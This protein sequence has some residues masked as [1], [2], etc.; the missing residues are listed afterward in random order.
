M[1][2]AALERLRGA[3]SARP[4]EPGRIAV[5]D[6]LR[7]R[8]RRFEA[9]FVLGLEEGSL[10]A[11]RA[12]VAVPRRRA[13]ARARPRGSSAPT[14]SAATATSSTPP[15][16]ARRGGSISCAR[17]PT[18][19]GAPREP[20]P[21]WH[22]VAAVFDPEDV[23]RATRRRAL[24]EL[25]V[26]DRRARRPS[27]SGCARSRGSRPTRDAAELALALA[28]ANGWARR[29]GRAR[30]AF[31][32]ETRLR[33]P[34]CSRQLGARSDVR[35]HRARALRRLL[36]GLALRA[37]RSTR[38]RSTPRPTRCCAA[39][40]P[41]RRS[42]RSTRGLPKEL[43]SDR[44]TP[45]NARAGA[46]RS[47]A[48]CLD[49]ALRGGVRLDLERGRGGR[50]ARGALARPRAVPPRRGA[51]AARASC[52]GASRSASA[53]S[54]RRPSSSAGSSSAT[55]SSLSGKI[56][57]I[58]VDPFSARGIVQDYKSGKG[59]FSARADR[60]RA[61]PAGAALHA[62]A[63]RPRRDRAARRRLPRARRSSRGARGMLRD[64]ARDDLP[65]LQGERLPRR[66]DVLGAGRDGARARARL[67]R[68]G[69]AA[70]TSRHDPKGGE[71]PA[72]C[73]LWTMCRVRARRDERAAARGGRGARRGVRLGRRRAR[74]RRPC[75]SSGSC[76]RSATTG[77][78]STR[79]SSI[80][81]TRKAA[82]ELRSRIRAALARARP[83]R[84]R[85]RARRRL[86]LDH[87][88]LLRPAPA[89]ASVR[90][91]H[92]PALPR[93]RRRAGRGRPRRGVRARARRV[94]R[95][96]RS[97]AARGC[98]RPTAA[99]RLRRMLTGVYETL[100]SAGRPLVLEL[101]E[102]R[103]P[104]A[105]A[106]RELREA[107]QCLLDDPSATDEPAR[108]A[109][110]AALDLAVAPGAAARPRRALRARGDRAANYEEARK[111]RRAGGARG[112]SRRATRTCSR[113][114]STSSRPST[115]PA[116]ERE[117]ALD[118]E[119]LQLYARDLLAR[120]RPDPR[121]RAAALPRD[122]GRRVPGHERAPVRADRPASRG[123]PGA[124]DVFFVGDEFQSIYGFRHAD[125]DVFRERREQ[126]AQRLPLTE[127]Y[128]SRP[129]VLAAVNHLFGDGVRRRLPAAR[130]LGRVP[131]PGLRPSGR[132]AR[133][134]QGARTATR[135]E[136]WRR[137]EARH[138]ARRVRE[139][140]D[141][142]AATPGE[143]VLLFAAGTDAEW[144]EEELRRARAAD[145]SRDRPRATSASSRSS[146]CC[147][148]C[149]CC[150]TATTTR[151]SS[152][153][154]AS[155]FVGVSNDALVLIRRH[156][157]R[158]PLFTGIERSLPDALDD[159]DE[160]LIRAFKQR[161][162]RLVAASGAALARAALRAD[163][164]RARLRPRRARALGR[165]A[166]LR[167]PAQADAARAL[168][169][170]AARP[171][172]RG[173]RRASSA[174]RRRSARRSSR[175]SP[176]RRAR[177]RSGC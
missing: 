127:N 101:G 119:D 66:G 113:S 154:L 124:K 136:H 63:A 172:H 145:L 55:G 106:R 36:V 24:S 39:R 104:R 120:R 110:R 50:A 32:R 29:L 59:A 25:D 166:P 87:P 41:T 34:A 137:A 90:R 27:A 140:V 99:T 56:D 6:L 171:R 23:A 143:I 14:R 139:L 19:D 97:G 98:S 65:G 89:S 93:A 107:A 85:A 44:V 15:A 102:L 121:A 92:R 157:G 40:S 128:R 76:A 155:P 2:I 69:S 77:S 20:S 158:R 11:A 35:R 86:D 169:R 151:R 22:E 88:R 68:S 84:P 156:A 146:T 108:A 5:L 125:V 131:R 177:T 62:G 3:G 67:R 173:L 122:H 79:C 73:D 114:C 43:G 30:R 1:L 7:A 132:A 51:L 111:R 49:D 153:V 71:C 61:A 144:Y 81:Y 129:E 48:R 31:E 47:C 163:R 117:S 130:G 148:T 45:E 100:R 133:H 141:A 72:W 4:A 150:A 33:N 123:G 42:T 161:Y 160:R 174:T 57:R 13:P 94:L 168:L 46:R 64:E 83:A 147:C 21:F 58:D 95:R 134:R 26:A 91:R 109:A 116:K 118:F 165:A 162:D 60:R 37:R 54:A 126:A 115:P 105:A 17:R 82:G 103:R 9:V 135:G 75:S 74:A 38:R 10:P 149:G 12:P 164:L 53:P 142:G 138:I 176:R 170:G 70:A 167:E 96:R 78:T 112:R 80:T 159:E 16:R 8:T 152:T 52:R 28:D 18:D 175:R